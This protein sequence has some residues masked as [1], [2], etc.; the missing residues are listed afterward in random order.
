LNNSPLCSGEKLIVNLS[1]TKNMKGDIKNMLFTAGAVAL[2]M[3]VAQ[4]LQT[5]VLNKGASTTAVA[6][7][8]EE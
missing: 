3:I 1:K 8:D 2:G 7:E 6:T 5:K 4:M